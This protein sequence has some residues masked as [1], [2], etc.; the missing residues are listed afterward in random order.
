MASQ[1]AATTKRC[2]TCQTDLPPNAKFCL[3][4][5]CRWE[6][7]VCRACSTTLPANAKFCLECGLSTVTSSTGGDA[8]TNLASTGAAAAATDLAPTG[9]AAAATSVPGSLGESSSSPR[10]QRPACLRCKA[11]KRACDRALPICGQC[12][13]RGLE[14]IQP[15]GPQPPPSGPAA[16]PPSRASSRARPARPLPLEGTAAPQAASAPHPGGRRICSACS[17][18]RAREQYVGPSW[19]TDLSWHARS[20]S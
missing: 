1:A 18:P 19:R 6:P 12:A 11:S 9:A 14:C 15:G 8:A 7:P 20:H 2:A 4:C 13:H 16:A 5:G 17:E 10:D 3:A